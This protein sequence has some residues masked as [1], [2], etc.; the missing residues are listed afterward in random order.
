[1]KKFNFLKESLN[2]CDNLCR[3]GGY[4]D[5]GYAIPFSAIL[6]SQILISGGVG[7]TA[8]M[9]VDVMDINPKIKIIPVDYSFSRIRMII[10]TIYHYFKKGVDWKLSLLENITVFILL[11]KF[12]V[13]KK[14]ITKRY[15]LIDILNEFNKESCKYLIKLDIEGSEF[16]V[17][18]SIL[19]L[20]S[21]IQGLCI[22]FHE[23]N[24]PENFKRLKEFVSKTS[25]KLIFVSVNESSIKEDEPTILELSFSNSKYLTNK[26]NFLQ[27]SFNP[28]KSDLVVL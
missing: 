14:Y 25:L 8:R 18:E 11:N 26:H 21:N 24:N 17:L 23:L 19:T 5:G 22:E 20:E 13:V 3:V 28:G 2:D 10:R 7:S 4:R 16:E 1:M 6:N 9:E 12:K 27:A 15:S